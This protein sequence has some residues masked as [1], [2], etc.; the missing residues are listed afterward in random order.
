MEP[1]SVGVA[2]LVT[3]LAGLATS[4]GS[5]LAMAIR[6]SNR[7][8]MTLAMGFSAGAMLLISFVELLPAAAAQFGGG[9]R[10]TWLA[11]AA[12]LVA[13]GLAAVAD[14][15]VPDEPS[16]VVSGHRP[17]QVPLRAAVFV[18]VAIAVHN[19]PEGMATFFLSL[20]QATIGI[21]VAVAVGLHNIPE[22]IAVS[23]PI[24]AATGS[25][26]R[27]FAYSALSGLAEPLGALLAYLVLAPF[28][29]DA[30]F[31]VLSAGVAGLMVYVSIHQVVPLA[32]RSELPRPAV[33][34]VLGGMAVMAVS[35]ALLGLTMG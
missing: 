7:W 15:V 35:M 17:G 11:L 3:T 12:F 23:A 31:G 4:I 5:L 25:R 24:L 21:S 32:H 33:I 1:G 6:P 34:G 29:S 8:A 18:A 27:A 22:G 13:F 20:D 10:G 2:L 9:S 14:A 30:L 19:I 28:L 26:A 16:P